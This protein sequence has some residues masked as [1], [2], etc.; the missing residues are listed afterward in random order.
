MCV[1]QVF[2]AT[3]STRERREIILE[4]CLSYCIK[5]TL[6][7]VLWKVLELLLLTVIVCIHVHVYSLYMYNVHVY[8]MAC[9][10]VCRC[11]LWSL[12]VMIHK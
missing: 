10:C 8:T 1:V 11:S 7:N 4:H 9:V 6:Q 5:V 12:Y 2:D 3:N